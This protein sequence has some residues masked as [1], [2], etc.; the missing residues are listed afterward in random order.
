MKKSAAILLFLLMNIVSFSQEI[1]DNGIDDDFDGLIDLQDTV[2]CFCA[3]AK[4]DSILSSLIPNPSFE[5]RT[6]CPNGA[7]QLNCAV[8]W[9]QASGA[10][11]DYFN[12]CGF[13]TIGTF[14]APPLPLPNGNGYVGFFNN[15]STLNLPYKEYV[16]TCLTDTTK[17]GKNYQIE[18]FL[19]NSFGNLT[20]EMAIYGTTNCA[21]L[22]FGNLLPT[23]SAFCPTTTA[24]LDWDLLDVDTVTCSATGWI[25][26]SLSFTAAQN[27]AAIVLGGSCTNNTGSNYYYMDNLI[28]NETALFLPSIN[29]ED[30]GH[31]CQGNL[32]LKANFDSVPRFFQWYKDSIAIAGATDS[33]YSVPNGGLGNYQL[34]ATYDT[35]C[36]L[37]QVYRLDTTIITF[38]L[39]SAGTCPVGIQTGEI[40]ARNTSSGTS[41]YEYQLDNS[42]FVTDTGFSSLTAGL[43]TMTVQDSN[44]C[45]TSQTVIVE[46][47]PEPE[48]S[49]LVDSVCLGFTSNFI[50]QSSVTTGSITNWQWALPGNPTIPNPT[51]VSPAAGDLP[52]TLTVTSDSGC[53]DDT[54]ILA[55]VHALP[56]PSF[57]FSPQELY[58]FN[59]DVCFSNQSTGATSYSWDF[60]FNG[61]NGRSTL[62][63]PCTVRFPENN[64]KIYQVVLT[65]ENE[66]GCIDSISGAISILDEFLLYIPSAFSPN[67]DGKN[68]EFRIFSAGVD[69]F[70]IKIFNNWGELMFETEESDQ[71]WDGKHKGE[72]VPV[73]IYP[74]R[75][76]L[77]GENGKV[78]E[79][80]G[81]LSVVR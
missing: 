12:T 51:F 31:Y 76:V 3:E 45:Q 72:L 52:I 38:D 36:V 67:A 10:T 1:C 66:F 4:P 48:A 56:V 77:K 62:V 18:F 21:N 68:D 79:V 30:A 71:F 64:E 28:L 39:D 2:D 34:L 20:T 55:V 16:G 13:I 60:D 14:P 27:Y 81:H 11:S 70:S 6:C 42:A 44:G 41:P 19:A 49:F 46:S 9:V 69:K 32:V 7:S 40:I 78:K 22:P 73:G 35:S 23:A 47:F 80:L 59:P 61:T 65:A 29:I 43:Y 54:T 17:I 8:N 33:T 74:Y 50:D 37:T 5:Q 53:V 15:F 63:N 25:K 57:S 26:V 24:P 75:A 58:T